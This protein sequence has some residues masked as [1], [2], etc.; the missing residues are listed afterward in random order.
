MDSHCYLCG[1]YGPTEK[2]HIFGGAYRKKSEKFGFTVY[3]CHFCHNEP[4][5]GVH[6]NKE[7][8]NYLKRIAQKEYEQTHTREE[9]IA[10]FSKNFIMED[11]E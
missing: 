4:P 7:R 3:L 9:F 6:F 5:D 2:H 11:E 8:R 10:E 1:K